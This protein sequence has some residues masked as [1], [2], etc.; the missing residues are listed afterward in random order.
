MSD[1]LPPMPP[2]M[3]VESPEIVPQTQNAPAVRPARQAVPLGRPITDLDEAWRLAMNIAQ[4]RNVQQDLRGNAADIFMVFVWG[5]ELGIGPMQSLANISIVSGSPVL[6]GQLLSGLLRR[7]G[8]MI[9]E[10]ESSDKRAAV[11][12]TRS[13][14]QV[15]EAD[16]TID[17]AVR[18]KLIFRD[19]NTGE[20]YSKSKTGAPKPW[21][22]Y[23]P[24]ML[25]WRAVGRV[26]RRGCSEVTLGCYIEGEIVEQI[27]DA[28]PPIEE[29]EVVE[30]TDDKIAE[31][32]KAIENVA[33]TVQTSMF[34]NMSDTVEA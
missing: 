33:S 24:D 5:S 27:I 26:V 11:R 14:G 3:P 12:L 13:D 8:H 1:A 28:L 29:V 4:A 32:I 10:I 17:D 22:L 2:E 20:Y 34:L 25:W 31:E 30:N 23:T 9:E 18:A 16:F 15:W 19:P 6:R 7:E 21:Q